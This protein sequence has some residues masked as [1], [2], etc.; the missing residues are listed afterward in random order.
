MTLPVS[1]T[2]TSSCM[3]TV[4]APAGIGAP[5]KMRIAR[6]GTAASS[7]EAP[8]WTQSA[9]GKVFSAPTGRSSPRSA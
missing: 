1:S 7:A 6:P 3:K 4:S 5:V 2:R 9:T 8:A